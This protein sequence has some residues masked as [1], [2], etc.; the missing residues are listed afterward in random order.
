MGT[1]TD[2]HPT[3]TL[4]V[5]WHQWSNSLELASQSCWMCSQIKWRKMMLTVPYMPYK[6]SFSKWGH[7]PLREKFQT[8]I[9]THFLWLFNHIQHLKHIFSMQYYLESHCA[10]Q[11]NCSPQCISSETTNY[12]GMEQVLKWQFSF[13]ENQA[14]VVDDV[15]GVIECQNVLF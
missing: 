7:F 3:F 13:R 2:Y 14:A 1:K 10:A 15:S 6:L 12:K 4:P 8:K 9:L 5:L 11:C